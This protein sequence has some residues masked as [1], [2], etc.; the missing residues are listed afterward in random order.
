[1]KKPNRWEKTHIGL[2]T[3]VMTRGKEA[4]TSPPMRTIAD[5]RRYRERCS[6]KIHMVETQLAELRAAMNTLRRMS[7][8]KP[9]PCGSNDDGAP[10]DESA[11]CE[12][13]SGCEDCCYCEFE[14]EEKT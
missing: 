5:K 6:M 2:D 4:K 7:P 12:E 3:Y 10:C 11:W 14:A 8:T 1:M 13:C 9:T